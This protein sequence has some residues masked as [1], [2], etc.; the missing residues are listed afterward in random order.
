MG[1]FRAAAN[2]KRVR[3]GGGSPETRADG[4]SGRDPRKA[5]RVS[6]PVSLWIHWRY[7]IALT[8]WKGVSHAAPRR[9]VRR[10][11]DPAHSVGQPARETR[12]GYGSGGEARHHPRA[13]DGVRPE[14][15]TVEAQEGDSRHEGGAFVD[16][17]EGM[18]LGDATCANRKSSPS[19]PSCE[20]SLSWPT[21]CCAI[22]GTGPT[23]DLDQDGYSAVCF[24]IA[25]RAMN[26]RAPGRDK[27]HRRSRRPRRAD[28]RSGRMAHV[29]QARRP[30]RHQPAAPAAP[31]AGTE[32]A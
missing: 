12:P 16:V 23:S 8:R 1:A 9:P 14:R 29:R 25:C 6:K 7:R 20:S 18:R 22:M 3:S 10:S 21:P 28:A 11:V 32:P 5:S 2:D 4:D 27:R 24:A 13:S 17:D 15:L 26:G 19:P 31:I 30:G